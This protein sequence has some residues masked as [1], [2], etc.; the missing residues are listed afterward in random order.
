MNRARLLYRLIGR[1]LIREPV[2]TWITVLCVSIGVAVVVAIDLA[3]HA[4]AGSFRSSMESLQGSA[5]Y[6]ITRVGGIPDT[7]FGVLSKLPVPLEFSARVEAYATVA[8]TGERLPLFGVDILG[9]EAVRSGVGAELP[10]LE[11]LFEQRP[12]WVPETLG[13]RVG[14]RIDLA[15][16]DRL[17]TFTVQGLL[18]NSNWS[19]TSPQGFV[20]TDIALAQQVLDRI[21]LLDR[22]YVRDPSGGEGDWKALIAGALPS[23]A[24]LRPAGTG[25]QESR[26]LLRSF[27]WNLQVLSYIALIVGAF[28]VYNAVSV[29][30]VR[31]RDLIGVARALGMAAG[32]VRAGFLAE[33]CFFGAAGTLVGLVLGRVL[34]V[35]AVGLMGQTVQA[36]YVSSAPGDIAIRPWTAAVATVAGLGVSVAAA[37]WPAREASSVLP[38]EAMARARRDYEIRGASAYWSQAAG[39]CAAVSALLCTLPAWDRVP[40]AGF[41]GAFGLILAVAMVVPKVAAVSLGA[42]ARPLLRLLG[43]GAMLGSRTLAGSLGRTAVIVAALATATGMMVSVGIMVGSLRETL[44][45]WMDRQLQADLYVQA[46]ARS[47]ADA[48]ATFS[49]EVAKTIEGLPAVDDVDRLRR[50]PISYGGLPSTLALADFRVIG[51]RSKMRFLGGQDIAAVADTLVASKSVIASE[52][53]GSKH[54]LGAGD[55]VRL[56]IGN[57]AEEF[58]IA[59]IY[60]DYSAEHGFLLGHREILMRYLPDDRLTGVAVYVSAGVDVEAARS[61]VIESAAGYRVQVSRN[62]E[63]REGA[64][65]IFDRTFAITYALEAV[66]IFVAILGMSG[67][68][69]TLVVDR[70][71]EFGVLRALGAAKRQVR[72]LVL[73]QAG[74]LG[75]LAT[76]MGFVLGWLL[77]IVLVKVINKQSFGWTIQFHWPVA[78]LLG[79]IGVIFAAS[80]AAGT[81]PARIAA[82]QGP[83]DGMR[84]G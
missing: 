16:N 72:Q 46:E 4:A 23:G 51:R 1:P 77:S 67:A 52:A 70:R 15:V 10:D 28:L 84:G 14:E 12:V 37:W 79:A 56:P 19:G 21:G 13:V 55:T 47:G 57:G 24:S 69:L 3:G 54:G 58:E 20:V 59:G 62:R 35:G 48:A 63:L 60:Y 27:R 39:V 65:E 22:I 36:L 9:D 74:M 75:L 26:K 7:A 81:Y 31:R 29:S 8:A 45:V 71:A 76:S 17:E 66:A 30:V 32:T 42:A 50:Y 68:L 25:T 44:I 80:L 83:T 33:G 34:A 53:F 11:V 43:P 82:T 61:A 73:A 2:R 41:L 5:S 40:Y 6:E 49:E 64:T 18:G 78:I 38:A